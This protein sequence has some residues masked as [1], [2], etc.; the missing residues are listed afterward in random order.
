MPEQTNTTPSSGIYSRLPLSA[1]IAAAKPPSPSEPVSPMNTEAGWVL[2][3]RYP[4]STPHSDRLS[5]PSGAPA[6]DT[7]KMSAA[8]AAKY[9]KH[10]DA[11]SPSSPLPRSRCSSSVSG[12]AQR[13]E[14][15]AVAVQPREQGDGELKEDLLV[16]AQA[17]V[18][19]AAQLE[20]VV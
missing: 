10:E 17:E 18:A 15:G 7:R 6:P 16:G 9:Q 5:R 1:A 20:E 2:K 4:A 8:S 11:A 19:A 12:E 13:R 14:A 3:R